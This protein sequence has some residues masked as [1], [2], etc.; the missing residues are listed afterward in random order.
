M[1][2]GD[3][4]AIAAKLSKCQYAVG[5]DSE[6]KGLFG[7]KKWYTHIVKQTSRPRHTVE[8]QLDTLRCLGVFPHSNER[9]LF[10]HIPLSAEKKVKH[11]LQESGIKPGEYVHIHPVSRWMFKTVPI[12]TMVDVIHFL[13]G[14]GKKSGV[15]SKQRSCRNGDE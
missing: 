13:D 11:L 5:F 10:F 12:Q 8:K 2:E 9:D 6:N 15:N 3:R 1:T 7:K 4:G 14:K